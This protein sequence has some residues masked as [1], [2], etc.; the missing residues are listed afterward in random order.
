MDIDFKIMEK[1]WYVMKEDYAEKIADAAME[2]LKKGNI[3][4][5]ECI[6]AQSDELMEKYLMGENFSFADIRAVALNYNAAKNIIQFFS[7]EN[8]Y[9]V[10]SFV[11][12][13]LEEEKIE[14]KPSTMSLREEMKLNKE[15][16]KNEAGRKASDGSLI[17][18]Q[19]YTIE[20][21]EQYVMD[22][23]FKLKSE[24]LKENASVIADLV[25]SKDKRHRL[26]NFSSYGQSLEEFFA[27]R[28]L[29]TFEP[30]LWH[31]DIEKYF[32]DFRDFQKGK[33]EKFI[34]EPNRYTH[35]EK[36]FTFYTKKENRDFGEK[37]C[38]MIKTNAEEWKI[39]AE[40]FFK[41]IVSKLTRTLKSIPTTQ[42]SFAGH[43]AL[44]GY[45]GAMEI[46][47]NDDM[48]K[49]L[50]SAV[51]NLKLKN[52]LDAVY[53]LPTPIAKTI[54]LIKANMICV[55]D[56][57]DDEP[58]EI[59]DIVV[60]GL[61]GKVEVTDGEGSSYP[62]DATIRPTYKPKSV[63]GH[64][65]VGQLIGGTVGGV[66]GAVSAMEENYRQAEAVATYKPCMIDIKFDE[67]DILL[68]ESTTLSHCPICSVNKSFLQ[69]KELNNILNSL[70]NA[71]THSACLRGEMIKDYI[72]DSPSNINYS[73]KD[74]ESYEQRRMDE[75]K[76]LLVEKYP[77]LKEAYLKEKTIR[78]ELENADREGKKKLKKCKQ[79]Y[80]SE[81]KVLEKELGNLES[82]L[83][84]LGF[85]KGK[86]KRE[87]SSKIEKNKAQ[88]K[89]IEENYINEKQEL[90]EIRTG[91]VRK[92]SDSIK[93]YEA[94]FSAST[95]YGECILDEQK[96]GYEKHIFIQA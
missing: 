84:Q 40:R 7:P 53:F 51:S 16:E 85:F 3:E 42:A 45:A 55:V 78:T 8:G 93:G 89:L 39:V 11:E 13:G 37:M 14:E 94:K 71:R 46:H 17:V 74:F 76:S 29:E 92:I 65:M 91:L 12:K 23:V 60:F 79:A 33:Y 87:L 83:N 64:A 21:V 35:I 73:E 36:Y 80:D 86:E 67:I 68:A 77:E 90:E 75:L 22:N 59:A 41:P 4:L 15:K 27:D 54:L 2:E 57:Y 32:P 9:E 62:Y 96:R 43:A 49:R 61:N 1:T 63:I 28:Y 25:K 20:D 18:Q 66:I 5:E 34:V 82:S 88:Q 44:S 47:K 69:K 50:T 56:F 6:I 48:K 70:L 95:L 52:T 81:K 31:K 58:S 38:E 30:F 26:A 72:L 19:D 10:S 24:F